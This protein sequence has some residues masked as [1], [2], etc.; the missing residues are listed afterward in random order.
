MY[1]PSQTSTQRFAWRRPFSRRAQLFLVLFCLWMLLIA[2]RLFQV[3]VLDRD[4]YLAKY[5]SASFRR[6]I[7]PAMRGRILDHDGTPLAWSTRIFQLYYTV[8][9]E[10]RQLNLDLQAIAR[11]TGISLEHLLVLT[12]DHVGDTVVLVQRLA[13]ANL[14]ALDRLANPRLEVRSSFIRRHPELPRELRE[15]LG[16]TRVY[17]QVE[18]GISGWESYYDQRLRGTDGKYQVMVDKQGRWIPET[19]VAISPP[20]AGYDVFLPPDAAELLSE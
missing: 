17:G 13:P 16:E 19:W 5:Q 8:P 3:M 14:L 18:V 1:Q 4:D 11:T 12:Q 7:V 10:V 6:G 15:A 9:G 20:R 2:G